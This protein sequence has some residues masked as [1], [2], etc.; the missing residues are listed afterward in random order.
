M[1]DFRRYYVENGLYFVTTVARDRQPLFASESEIE[2]LQGVIAE[3]RSI[4]PF[5]LLGYAVLPDHVHFLLR[6]S[7]PASTN[8][9]DVMKS[10]KW[11]FT[12]NWK[13]AK[14][15]QQS[16][17]LWQERFWDHVIRNEKDLAA[18][19]DY[20]H[21]NPVKHGLVASPEDYEWSSFRQYLAEGFYESGWG[22]SKPESLIGMDLG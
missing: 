8:V 5:S 21:Y 12:R 4:R 9:S 3:V 15:V 10:I 1:P 18:H 17:S 13:K 20:I 11:N 22:N 6:P 2:I 19:L 7:S 14:G 16:V